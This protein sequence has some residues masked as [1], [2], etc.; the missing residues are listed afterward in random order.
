MHPLVATHFGLLVYEDCRFHHERMDT[1]LE[2]NPK[3][4]SESWIHQRN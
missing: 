2:K 3:M 4:K 1:Q